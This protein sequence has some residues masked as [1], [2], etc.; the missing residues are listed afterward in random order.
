MWL[1]LLAI[2]GLFTPART[3]I[4]I[5]RLAMEF[6]ANRELNR[7]IAAAMKPHEDA[8][9]RWAEMPGWGV[10]SAQQY[11]AEVGPERPRQTPGPG[12]ATDG[13]QRS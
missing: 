10:D 13:L 2:S 5:M 6:A 3:V 11:I 1:G 12:A 8:V 7:I 4:S 9:V